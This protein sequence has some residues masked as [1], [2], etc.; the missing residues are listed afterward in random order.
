[1]TI[2]NREQKIL[3]VKA[4]SFQTEL[5]EQLRQKLQPEVVSVV[6]TPI[7][8]VLVEEVTA[9]IKTMTVKPRRSGYYQRQ[10]NM[11]FGQVKN[12]SVL[13]FRHSNK[14]RPWSILDRYQRSLKGL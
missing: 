7:E 8:A 14:E 3:R 10:L 13:K 5:D 12:L 4:A 1:M 6:Q 9:Q 11:Q 2:A